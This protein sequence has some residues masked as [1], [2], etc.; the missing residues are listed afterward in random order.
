M[1]FCQHCGTQ[2]PDETA[3]CR[4]CGAAVIEPQAAAPALSQPSPM[5]LDYLR[6]GQRVCPAC[7]KVISVGAIECPYCDARIGSLAAP[8]KQ[9]SQ[10]QPAGPVKQG[11]GMAFGCL[12]FV[13][14]AGIALM[15]VSGLMCAGGAS[16]I[17]T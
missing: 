12:L 11:F 15:V 17:G 13:I 8:A 1:A 5:E 9:L 16:V 6:R 14:V 3:Y 10:Q 4:S 2:M 7:Q